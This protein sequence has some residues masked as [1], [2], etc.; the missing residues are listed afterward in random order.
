MESERKAE[1]KEKVL[2]PALLLNIMSKDLV[3]ANLG[4]I[5]SERESLKCLFWVP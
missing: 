4:I 1:H 2:T 3:D 5:E